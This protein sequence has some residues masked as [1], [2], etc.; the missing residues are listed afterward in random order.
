[1]P[2]YRSPCFLFA[3]VA[4]LAVLQGCA[5][6]DLAAPAGEGAGGASTAGIGAGDASLRV[7]AELPPPPATA[8][9][10]A[11]PVAVSDMLEVTV[12]QVP[13]LSRTVQVD[14]AGI[15]SLPLIGQVKA[16]GKSVQTLQRDIE[17]AYRSNYLQ[18][19]SVS[20]LVK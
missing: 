9:G 14:D 12:F 5:S 1:M 17:T 10:I 8:Q 3:F 6:S 20:V 11:Q 15:I 13:D 2:R 19:P 16:A 7:V 4:G 18:S